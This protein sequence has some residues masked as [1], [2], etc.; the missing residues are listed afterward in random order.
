MFSVSAFFLILQL[1]S[2][3]I[4]LDCTYSVRSWYPVGNAYTCDA[5]LVRIGETR[6]VVGVSQNHENGLTD[7][8]VKALRVVNQKIDLF[9]EDI[10]LFFENLE[11]IHFAYVPIKSISKEDLKPFPRLRYLGIEFG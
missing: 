4:I 3:S 8:D 10:E 11:V 6:D 1:T 7:W 2:A 5:R 9:P